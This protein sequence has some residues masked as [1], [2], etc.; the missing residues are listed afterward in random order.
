MRRLASLCLTLTLLLG[1]LSCADHDASTPASTD[2][3]TGVDPT[4]SFYPPSPMNFIEQL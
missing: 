2:N 3:N 4:T 1:L